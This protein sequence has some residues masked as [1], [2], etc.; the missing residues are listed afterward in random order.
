MGAGGHEA[1]QFL[2]DVLSAGAGAQQDHQVLGGLLCQLHFQTL[3]N[4]VHLPHANLV[5][6]G[7]NG[8]SSFSSS[9]LC[10]NEVVSD[11]FGKG[12]RLLFVLQVVVEGVE[13]CLERLWLHF[14][15]QIHIHVSLLQNSV[16][17]VIE[18]ASLRDQAGS[19]Q[20]FFHPNDDELCINLISV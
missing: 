16:F 12:I 18:G 13:L 1:H 14:L 2:V 9:L 11:L 7:D 10:C 4:S 17:E 6:N 8:E 3:E 20:G 15:L 5:M 19:G